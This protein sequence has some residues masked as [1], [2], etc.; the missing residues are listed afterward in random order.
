M[1]KN[2]EI[3]DSGY[4]DGYRAGAERPAQTQQAGCGWVLA[5]FVFGVLAWIIA[6]I[7]DKGDGRANKALG[8]CLVWVVV[9][10]VFAMIG[11]G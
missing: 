9:L 11:M 2:E 4:E 8:G 6:L 5:G 10:V 1:R 7:T 3:Y